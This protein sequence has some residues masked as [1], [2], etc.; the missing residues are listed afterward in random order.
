MLCSIMASTPDSCSGNRGSNPCRAI[1]K[2]GKR[3]CPQWAKDKSKIKIGKD[4][5]E[6]NKK[7]MVFKRAK[8]RK[9]K[10]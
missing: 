7:D 4:E 8:S 6:S 9:K 1:Y 2:M 5:S 10:K 3:M